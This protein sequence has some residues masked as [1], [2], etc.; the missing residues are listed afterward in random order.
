LWEG[1]TWRR[2][3]NSSA[4]RGRPELILLR[5][6]VTTYGRRAEFGVPNP[7]GD[8]KILICGYAVHTL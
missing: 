6:R 5:D 4:T 8:P 2:G 1:D 3:E 7:E